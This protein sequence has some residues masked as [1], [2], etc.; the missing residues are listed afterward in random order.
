M[1]K[2]L[3]VVTDRVATKKG[4]RVT[5]M[6]WLVV[7]V[8]LSLAVPSVRDYQVT[9]IDSLPDDMQSVVAGEKMAAYFGDSELLPAILVIQA[10]DKVELQD[11]IALTDQIMEANISGLK[12]IV[13]MGRL[14]ESAADAFFSEDRSTVILPANVD[15]K[16]D[17]PEVKEVLD[18]MTGIILTHTA[19]LSVSVTGPAGIAVDTTELFTRADLVLIMST[20]GIILVLLIVIYRSPLIAFIPLLASVF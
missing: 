9:A 8:C 5:L 16:L 4:M 11:V 7:M 17:T 18:Q 10:K 1:E 12:E 13:P 3:Q 2:W 14:P 15:A 20:V 6:I 19:D